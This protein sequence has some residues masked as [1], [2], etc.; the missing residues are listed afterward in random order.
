MKIMKITTCAFLGCLLLPFSSLYGAETERSRTLLDKEWRFSRF[1]PMPDKSERAEPA[2]LEAGDYDDSE[3][4]VLDIP[5]DW[6]IEGPFRQDLEGSTGKLPWRGIGWYRKRLTIPASD[7]GKNIFI[8][9]DGLM[10]NSKIYLNGEYVGSWPYGY[11]S[12]RLDFTKFIKF[13]EENVLAIR[14]NTVDMDSRWYPGAG[15]YRNVWLVKTSN[16][17]VGHWGTYITTPEAS[18]SKG[19]VKNI[20]TV[21]NRSDQSE[22]VQVSMSIYELADDTV[23]ERVKYTHPVKETVTIQAGE[24]KDIELSVSVKSPRLWSVESPNRYLVRTT[25]HVEDQQVDEYDTKMGFRTLKVTAHDG[26]FLNGKQVRIKGV[27]NHHDLGPLGAAVNTRAIE[28]QLELLKEMGCNSIRTAHN[29]PAPELLELCDK[30]GFLVQDECFDTWHRGKRPMDYNVLFEE[31]HEKDLVAMIKRDRNHPSVFMWS[32]GNEI[33]DRGSET[34][35]KISQ[36]LT[37]ICHREDPTR[38]T[39]NGCNGATRYMQN[40]FQNT[41]DVFGFNYTTYGYER[42]HAVPGNENKVYMA[43]ETASTLSSRGEYVFPVSEKKQNVTKDY[44]NSTF[45]TS[46]Y[47]VQGPNWGSLPD[48]SF[49]KMERNPACL[50]EY[51]WTGFDYLGEPTPFNSDIT[52]LLN[53]TDPKKK[54]E[55]RKQLEALGKIEVPSRSS[56]FGILDLAGFKKDRFYIY[57]AHWRPDFPMA[58]I[59]P[60]WN[61]PERKGLVTPV[62]VYTSGDEAELFLNGESLGRRKK[63]QYEYR[64]IWNDVVYEPGTLTVVSYKFGK[65]WATDTVKTTS[66]PAAVALDADRSSIKADGKDCSFITV[67]VVDDEG[68]VVPRTRNPVTFSIQGPGRIVAMGSGDPTSHESFHGNKRN[69]FNGKCLVIVSATAPGTITLT[70]E[71]PNLKT[72]TIDLEGK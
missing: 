8:D 18:S 13:G 62:H 7:K 53:F 20:V 1:G 12:F 38:V 43:T 25:L 24:S 40:G 39:V 71:S 67:S 32:T 55:M 54:E 17:H 64:L 26:F 69:I 23:G 34:G 61:W 15:I 35:L 52:N 72:V 44:T 11:T 2:G 16:I 29:L 70:A 56:Y 4:R 28:R 14:L 42:F 68:L 31:W 48:D 22:D 47:D 41:V 3:W 19:V 51:V 45:H 49:E 21:D 36:R 37:D 60:H 50:G 57:Q 46:S 10:A 9:F 65:E 5:H 59:L 6:G 66:E 33:R 58:H 30:M 27:C 63:G